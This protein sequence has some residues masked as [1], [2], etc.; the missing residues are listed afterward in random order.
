MAIIEGTSGV[1]NLIGTGDSDEIYG[2]D[3]HDQLYGGGGNDQLYGGNGNDLLDGGTG[4][5]VMDGG[6]G[7]D[8]YYVDDSGDTIVETEADGDTDI[9]HVSVTYFDLG[10]AYVEQVYYADTGNATLLG[11]AGDNLLSTSTGNDWIEGKG[12]NDFLFG[13]GGDDHLDGGTGNDEL[14]GWQG[15]DTMIGG[16]GDDVYNVDSTSDVVVEYAGE[17]I[18]TVKVRLSTYTIPTN[19]ENVDARHATGAITITGNSLDN[20]IIVGVGAMT[21][22][23]GAGIDTVSYQSKG[24]AVTIDLAN[25][26]FGGAAAGDYLNGIENVTGSSSDDELRGNGYANVLDGGPGA[27]LMVGRGGH[28]IYYVDNVGDVV[29]E[30]GGGGT[31]EVRVRNLTSY[32]LTDY[33]EKLTNIHNYLF[34]GTGNA[35][36]NELNGGST[37]DYLYG[38]AGNDALY[39]GAGDDIL[40]GDGEHDFLNGGVGADDMYG[41]PGNDIF[42]VDNVGDTVTELGGQGTDQVQTTLSSYTLTAHVENLVYCAGGN[43]HGTGNNLHNTLTGQAGDDTLEG[44]GGADILYGNGGS[45]LLDGGDGDDLLLGGAGADVLTSGDGGDM[46][47]FSDGDTG[48]GAQADRITDFA[49]WYDKI[50]LRGIDA[51]LTIAGDQAFSFIGTAAFSGVAGQLRYAFDGTDT[52]LQGD[53]DGDGVADVEIVFTGNVALVSGDFYL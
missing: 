41:G 2:F 46:Y 19:V 30:V 35:L 22:Y 48:T 36:A 24:G 43:F 38:G 49:W 28:D 11:S 18:D 3:G 40:H 23:A 53:Q 44:M 20:L 45:D 7:N 4:A 29:V 42:V 47:R 13:G 34:Y 21:V 39:G 51:D 8:T 27:D 10:S 52:W 12:G 15:A 16:P 32:T 14:D 31:D 33:V 37:V 6:D 50:D 5:D 26:S 25:Y 17:G 1:D 9:V